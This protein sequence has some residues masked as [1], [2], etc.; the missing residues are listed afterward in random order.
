MRFFNT[1]PVARLIYLSG[2]ARTKYAEKQKQ[3]KI[4]Q[5]STNQTKQTKH[6]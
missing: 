2:A 5:N 1:S 3:N 6:S 4:K